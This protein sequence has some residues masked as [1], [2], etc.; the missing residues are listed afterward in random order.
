MISST[1][2][3]YAFIVKDRKLPIVGLFKYILSNFDKIFQTNSI[4]WGEIFRT[5]FSKFCPL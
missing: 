3:R 1:A 4:S 5:H 2:E